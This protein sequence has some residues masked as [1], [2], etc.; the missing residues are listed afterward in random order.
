M[1]V[2]FRVLGSLEVLVDGRAVPVRAGKQRVVLAALLLHAGRAVSVGELLDVLWGDE[3]PTTAR[4]ALQT[5]IARLRKLLGEDVIATVGGG[6]VLATER[7]DLVRFHELVRRAKSTSKSTRARLLGEALSLWRGA[8]LA[9]VPSVSLHANEID[10]LKDELLDVVEQRVDADLELGKHRELVGEL[11]ALVADHPVRERFWGQYMLAL[12]RS[13]R[14][15]EALM[16]FRD[17]ASALKERLGAT[18][19]AELRALHRAMLVGDVAQANAVPRSAAVVPQQLPGDISDFV[20]REELLGRIVGLLDEGMQL[21]VVSG[22][23]G[24]GKTALA[25]RVAHRLKQRFPDGQLHVNLHGYS[26]NAR[27]TPGQV[28]ARFLRALGVPTDRVPATV[29]EQSAMLRSELSDRR[30]LL[31]LD[32]AI[33]AEQVLPLI[34]ETGGCAVVVTSRGVLRELI[35]HERVEAVVLSVLPQGDSLALLAEFAGGVVRD[36]PEASEE[37][38]RLCGSLPLALR[39]AG[40]NIAQQGCTVRAYVDEV[41]G[42]DVLSALTVDG[43][44]QSAVRAAF[45]MSYATLSDEARRVF[46]LLGLVPGPDFTAWAAAS[47]LDSTVDGAI[48]LLDELATA[49]LV[50]RHQNDRFQFHDLLRAY[51]AEQAMAEERAEEIDAA[52]SRLLD[53]HLFAAGTARTLLPLR[54]YTAKL[55][56][57]V[58]IGAPFGDRAGAEAWMEDERANLRAVVALAARRGRN[59]HL[60]QFVDVLWTYLLSKGHN[61]DCREIAE[62]GL[63]T[64]IAVDNSDAVSTMHSHLAH[65]TWISGDPRG[66][67]AEYD[68]ALAAADQSASSLELGNILNNCAGVHWELGDNVQAIE[69]LHRALRIYQ[70]I[71]ARHQEA[72][73][74]GNLGLAHQELGHFHEAAEHHEAGMRLAEQQGAWDSY[75]NHLA[76]LSSARY[77]LG[78]F[79]GARAAVREAIERCAELGLHQAEALAHVGFAELLATEGDGPGAMREALR[80]RELVSEIDK[81]G[82]AAVT[83]AIGSAHLAL[84][85]LAQARASYREAMNA[86]RRAGF[87]RHEVDAAIGLART[88]LRA[89]TTGQAIAYARTAVE[90]ARE[91]GIRI[92]QAEAMHVL[93]LLLHETG[94]VESAREQWRLAEVMFTE[95]G[96]HSAATV[97]ALLDG[98]S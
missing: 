97:R 91:H 90:Q 76:N 50:Q 8:V 54:A 48:A 28:L 58:R 73:T 41:R 20:G 53:W 79:T 21:V 62:R 64:A 87:V 29:D 39:I 66:A 4:N 16:A 49:N 82:N 34:P 7:I 84:G 81:W 93:G 94:E 43:D 88:G 75:A 9:D 59:E 56:E 3:P 86:A 33:D 89:K 35:E 57:H 52:V 19:S 40:A 31:V 18:P 60:W 1:T 51:A 85:E 95:M 22:P 71:Q 69:H 27:P 25:V 15:A 12:Y 17:L 30:V 67:L 36:D 38:V 61:V 32:N 92:R 37:L 2:E 47:L 72:N 23:P 45:A 68:K 80:G 77:Q 26:A 74:R 70:D 78:D 44:E 96:V 10:Q 55:P 46:R 14:Q 65:L 42:G 5:H 83:I 13:E 98:A 11:R 24:V 6:Y 63:A